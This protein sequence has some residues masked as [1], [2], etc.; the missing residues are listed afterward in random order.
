MTLD[1]FYPKR[2]GKMVPFAALMS[3]GFLWACSEDT[4]TP[5]NTGDDSGKDTGD[6]DSQSQTAWEIEMVEDRD[7]GVLAK[8]VAGPSDEVAVAYF[9]TKSIQDGPCDETEISPPPERLRQELRFAQRDS[10]GAWSVQTVDTP[11]ISVDPVGLSFLYGPDGAPSL[12][13]AG[14]VPEQRFCGPND[15][16]F[17][18]RIDGDWVSQTAGALSADSATG[19]PESDSGFVVGWWPA[20]AFD[21]GGNPAVLH[22]D[23]HF[24]SMQ[25]DDLYRAD[26]EFAWRSG[27]AWDIH[28]AVDRGE[29]AG[30]YGALLFDGEDR[31]NAFYYIPVD[32]QNGSRKGVWA[33][34]R[35]SAG[36]WEK[37]QLQ[38]GGIY[39]EIAAKINPISGHLVVAF[40]SEKDGAVRVRTLEDPKEFANKSAWDSRI[41]GDPRFVEGH[42]VSLAFTPAGKAAVAYHRCKRQGTSDGGCNQNDEAVV[43]ATQGDPEWKI[44]VVKTAAKGSCGDY[45]ALAIDQKGT[46][47]IAYRCT[48]ETDDGFEFRVYVA[49]KQL[50]DGK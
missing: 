38:G 25:H 13:Y 40:F 3:L 29:G 46:A 32:S 15:A 35:E 50:G 42:H 1:S 10:T 17:N 39:Q 30:N 33:A 6:T 9:A 11:V 19:F 4:P 45:T 27:G 44:E 14:G 37:V 22:K 23:V 24:G 28:E 8:I 26:L 41:V 16:I 48:I 49:H 18:Q 12:A 2:P 31:P 7:V 43:L 34:R 36:N 5:S 21:Q 20:L 47:Y